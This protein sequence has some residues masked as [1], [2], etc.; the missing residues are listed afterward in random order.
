MIIRNV[1]WKLLVSRSFPIY[2]YTLF[3]T[4]FEKIK[5]NENEKKIQ[6][7]KEGNIDW[8]MI[9]HKIKH[10]IENTNLFYSI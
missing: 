9:K 1:N 3:L 6:K 4:I 2:I 8:M 5:V 7:T 10:I